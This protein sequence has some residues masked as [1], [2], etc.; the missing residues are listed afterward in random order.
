MDVFLSAR[1]REGKAHIM[2][3]QTGPHGR[4]SVSKA[5]RRKGAHHV[6]SKRTTWTYFCQQGKEKERR[7]SCAVKQ[8]HMD[9]FLSARQREEKAHIM[10]GQR[11]PHGRIS[12]SK[13][14]RR[15]GAHHVRSKRT[16]WTYFCQQGKEKKRRTSCAV[17][18]D[19]MDVFLSARQREGK[20]HIMCGQTG[21]H[22]RISVSKAKRRK[23]AHHV[24][25]KRTTWTYFCQ[26]GKEKERR[27]S[28]A[29]K[30]DHMDVF[31]SARQREGKAHIMCGQTG[32]HG[33]ISFSKAKSSSHT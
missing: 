9:V 15:K 14:K 17:K 20:A 1:Q 23:G 18:E 8:D 19:H 3:G 21:P 7:T 28:C 33:R 16:T 10:C 5:K 27:T 11:G 2:C 24:R 6:R 4:I 32:P 26:Q 30:Q 31:L 13:A 29:V 12:V 25:S 22:G